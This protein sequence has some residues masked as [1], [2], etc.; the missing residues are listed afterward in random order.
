VRIQRRG[1]AERRGKGN[2]ERVKGNVKGR[3]IH[4][5]INKKR[6]EEEPDKKLTKRMPG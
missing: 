6:R 5:L 2:A 4:A 1:N 3:G